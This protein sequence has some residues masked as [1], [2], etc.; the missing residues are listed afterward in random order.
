MGPEPGPTGARM[1]RICQEL[2]HLGRSGAT[3][4]VLDRDRHSP[5]LADQDHQLLAAGHAGV[6][7]V[8][9]EQGSGAGECKIR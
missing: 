7:R 9:L 3:G 2:R 8:P 6:D 4:H 1:D 5:G